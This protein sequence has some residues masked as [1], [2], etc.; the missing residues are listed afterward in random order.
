MENGNCPTITLRK[1]KTELKILNAA[2]VIQKINEMFPANRTSYETW[3]RNKKV[4]E[5]IRW[6]E[7]AKNWFKQE[8]F[9]GTEDFEVIIN[10]PE[11]TLVETKQISSFPHTAMYADLHEYQPPISLSVTPSEPQVVQSVN[12][13]AYELREL[14]LE[15]A[16]SVVNNHLKNVSLN[17]FVENVLDVSDKFYSFVENRRKFNK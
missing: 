8:M 14:I 2:A 9:G 6:Q 5:Q 16:I 1:G 10:G 11:D 4:D 7:A 12:K 17:E 13:N 3:K 15:N